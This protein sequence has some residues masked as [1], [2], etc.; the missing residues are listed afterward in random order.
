[1]EKRRNYVQDQYNIK[2][3]KMRENIFTSDETKTNTGIKAVL[4]KMA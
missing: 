2:N 1:M 4:L 3:I